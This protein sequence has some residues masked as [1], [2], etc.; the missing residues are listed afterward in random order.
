M[1]VI[2]KPKFTAVHDSQIESR[3]VGPRC[4]GTDVFTFNQACGWYDNSRE[5]I[6]VMSS[7]NRLDSGEL[8]DPDDAYLET[9]PLRYELRNIQSVIHVTRQNID[10]LNNRLAAFQP[11][12]P[13]Y[14]TEYQ[15]LTNKLHELESKEQNLNELLNSTITGTSGQDDGQSSER[16]RC[17]RTPLKSLLRAHLPNQQ[18]TSVQVIN[19]YYFNS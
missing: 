15:E 17:P 2:G 11:P 10:A 5:F 13:I 8:S 3:S 12:P 19:S 4:F 1:A 18:R 7:Y 9:D 14:L 16:Y 6:R